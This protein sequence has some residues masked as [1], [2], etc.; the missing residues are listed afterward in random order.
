MRPRGPAAPAASLGRFGQGTIKLARSSLRTGRPTDL[1]VHAAAFRLTCLPACLPSLRLP[2]TAY[3]CRLPPARLR[4]CL[5]Y[6]TLPVPSRHTHTRSQTLDR[7]SRL[8]S[9]RF[10]EHPIHFHGMARGWRGSD[11]GSGSGSD[12]PSDGSTYLPT[13]VLDALCFGSF[14]S[15][16]YLAHTHTCTFTFTFT[17]TRAS[18]LPPLL[19]PLRLLSVCL[20]GWLS[21]AFD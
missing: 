21:R 12:T 6:P 14:S 18:S 9:L 15:V 8:V 3:R 10:G 1:I 17:F 19:L 7:S 16:Y 13:L 4:P 2:P 5:P 11:G 20:A